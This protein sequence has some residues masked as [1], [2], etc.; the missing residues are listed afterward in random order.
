MR[1]YDR[2]VACGCGG[3][4]GRLGVC[5]SVVV[6]FGMS[7]GSCIVARCGQT[8]SDQSFQQLAHCCRCRRPSGMCVLCVSCA[9]LRTLFNQVVRKV[10]TK[11]DTLR[12]RLREGADV[13][14]KCSV[15]ESDRRV[16]IGLI[17][18][19]TY[20]Y[21]GIL[22][23]IDRRRTD[24]LAAALVYLS[25]VDVSVSMSMLNTSAGVIDVEH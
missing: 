22:L 1:W 15:N 19:S 8:R 23:R 7:T 9:S 20:I 2:R 5:G 24:K 6:T 3:G 12:W 4:W 14:P 17:K 11:R 25:D 18:Q 10:R 21:Y 16:L 13:R